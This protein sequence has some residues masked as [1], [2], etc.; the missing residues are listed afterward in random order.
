MAKRDSAG[1]NAA[2]NRLST[3]ELIPLDSLAER[4]NVPSRVLERWGLSGRGGRFLD[5]L[6]RREKWMSSLTAWERF[7]ASSGVGEPVETG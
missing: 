4:V 3:E 7:Q 5:V 2:I 6:K 1:I